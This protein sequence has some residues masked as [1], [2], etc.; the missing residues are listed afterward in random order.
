MGA[1]MDLQ[2]ILFGIMIAY[3]PSLVV[4]IW[5]TWTVP[6]IDPMD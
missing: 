5:L 1:T 3:T 4:V 2:S 6:A